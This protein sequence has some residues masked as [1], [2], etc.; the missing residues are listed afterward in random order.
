MN[1]IHLP[2]IFLWDF[3]FF[4]YYNILISIWYSVIFDYSSLH[5]AIFGAQAAWCRFHGES[6][7]GAQS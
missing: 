2:F 4:T 3:S 5:K 6:Q 1:E 7:G